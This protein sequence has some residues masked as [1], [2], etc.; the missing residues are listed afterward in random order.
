MDLPAFYMKFFALCHSSRYDVC[1]SR[2]GSYD[3]PSDVNKNSDQME[4]KPSPYAI[5][6]NYTIGNYDY[7]LNIFSVFTICS[8]DLRSITPI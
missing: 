6:G 3:K 5:L 7:Y 4:N 8:N 2:T 1:Q